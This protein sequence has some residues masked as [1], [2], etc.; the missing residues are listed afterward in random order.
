[1]S[2]L[3]QIFRSKVNLKHHRRVAGT[4]SYTTHVDASSGQDAIE[5]IIGARNEDGVNLECTA[6]LVPEPERLDVPGSVAVHISGCKIGYLSRGD[7]QRYRDFLASAPRGGPALCDALIS[8]G[9]IRDGGEGCFV[10][11]LDVAWPLRFDEA[12]P[13]ELAA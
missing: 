4:G 5:L 12:I 6:F 2:M 7:G 3:Q 9:W 10:V 11:Q 13:L 1:M 8:G